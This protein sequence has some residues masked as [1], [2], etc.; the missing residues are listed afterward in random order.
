MKNKLQLLTGGL[1]ALSLG[2]LT[3]CP[4]DDTGSNEDGSSGNA[5]TMA[6]DGPGATSM[7]DASGS[8]SSG[9]SSS[10][11][12]PV[13]AEADNGAMCVDGECDCASSE[14]FLVGPL[15]GVCSDCDADEDCADSTGFGCNFGNPLTGV[16]AV[17]STTGELGEGCESADACAEGLFCPTLIEVSGILEAATCSECEVDTDCGAMQICAPTYDIANI[18]GHYRC[19]DEMTIPDNEGCVLTGTGAECV[20]GNCAP[21]S[22]EGIPVIAVCSPC[23]EDADCGGGTCQ[24]PG[25][26]LDGVMLS[27]VPGMCV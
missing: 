6:T 23:N 9:G 1:L 18:A 20:S 4:S 3:A 19:V 15:G 10:T 27:L 8:G 12:A 24:L 22:L 7:D 16:P 5:T 17:C 2:M 14:C 26:A 11:T 25:I 21:A 13:C